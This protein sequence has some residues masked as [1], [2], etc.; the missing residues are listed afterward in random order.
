MY[1]SVYASQRVFEHLKKIYTSQ[2]Y[3]QLR[4]QYFKE[5]HNVTEI[6]LAFENLSHAYACYGDSKIKIDIIRKAL[7]SNSSFTL[8]TLP[9]CEAEKTVIINCATFKNYL[10]DKTKVHKD[11][12]WVYFMCDKF[13][14]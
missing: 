1:A 7:T 4:Y 11:D 5:A 12:E 2:L 14:I 3:E 10:L 8:P 6:Q 9:S 13:K